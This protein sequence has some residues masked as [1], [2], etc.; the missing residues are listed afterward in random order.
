MNDFT[1]RIITLC[2]LTLCLGC[3]PGLAQEGKQKR[4]SQPDDP[5][6]HTPA[7]Q[8]ALELLNR[9]RL[10][11]EAAAKRYGVDLNEGLEDDP[12]T[13]EP[14]QPLA[15][16]SHLI[17]AARAHSEWMFEQQQLSHVGKNKTMPYER[18]KQADYPFGGMRWG[19]AENV[20]MEMRTAGIEPAEAVERMHRRMFVDEGNPKRGHRVN[21][22]KDAMSEAGIGIHSGEIQMKGRT[23]QAIY[24][25]Q[26]FA[27]AGNRGPFLTGVVYKDQDGDEFYSI[28]EGQAEVIVEAVS[29]KDSGNTYQTTT[30]PAGDYALELPSGS[31]Q[32]TFRTDDG[33]DAKTW[34]PDEPVEIGGE[35]VKVDWVIPGDA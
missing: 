8:L 15:P 33:D 7:E 14:K 32:V 27:N 4:E 9:T 31:Y 23:W 28:G 17:H 18:M 5:P 29:T 25:T 10:D 16:E 12:I 3:P 20:A 1:R 21:M 13:A 6:H 2:T 30:H 34:S 35:N 24:E 19:S 22:L 26:N 11:P